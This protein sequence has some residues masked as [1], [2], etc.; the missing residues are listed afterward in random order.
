MLIPLLLIDKKLQVSEP[1]PDSVHWSPKHPG[2]HFN[3][4][5]HSALLPHTSPKQIPALQGDAPTGQTA[6]Q[7]NPLEHTGLAGLQ[8]TITSLPPHLISVGL[9][10]SLP[11]QSAGHV[12]SSP[13]PA[14]QI[15]LPQTGKGTGS[16]SASTA[17]E[18]I[19]IKQTKAIT[20]FFISLWLKYTL[21]NLIAHPSGFLINNS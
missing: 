17:K 10:H 14:S 20:L 4:A 9:K 13:L 12:S 8:S 1:L 5:G 3:P 18:N 16:I 2:R 15:P 21:S 6:T 11:S 7:F 19:N